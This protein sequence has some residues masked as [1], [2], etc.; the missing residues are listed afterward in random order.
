MALPKVNELPKF[1]VTLPSNNKTVTCRPFM[2]KEQKLLLIALESRDPKQMLMAVLDMINSCIYEDV[3][4]KS[5]PTFDVEYTFTQLRLNSVGETT[6][7]TLPCSK[8]ETGNDVTIDL[9]EVKINLD[10]ANTKI[11]LTDKFTLNMK[12]PNFETVITKEDVSDDAT[13]A[14]NLMN[15]IKMSLHSLDTE[16]EQ[17]LFADETED[18]IDTFLENLTGGQFEDIMKFINEL[19]TLKHDV[20]FTCSSCGHENTLTLRGLQDF[21]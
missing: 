15:A 17:I 9:S 3:D 18:S 1:L 19:P 5:W 6:N 4:V 13:A 20:N 8:C 12:Y 21:F 10:D 11:K 16:E 7:I 2:V 14:E